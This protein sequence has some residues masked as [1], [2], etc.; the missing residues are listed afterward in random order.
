[1]SDSLQSLVQLVGPTIVQV[2]VTAY[3]PMDRGSAAETDLVIS[4]QRSLGSGVVVDPSGYIL[5]NEHVVSG[6]RRVQVVLPSTGGGPPPGR[7]EGGRRV[8]AQIVGS[9]REFDLAL[10]KID[11]TGLRALPLGDSTAL[12]Q[13]ELVFAFGSPEGLRNSVS[14]G[15]VSAAARQL[16]PDTPLAYIQT[17]AAINHGNSGG[18]LV[19]A[20]GEMVGMN[21]FIYSQSG[22]SEGLGFALPSALIRVAY[23]KLREFG[24]LHRAEVGV[25]LQTVTP[26]L[27]T[28]LH[29]ARQR[30]LIVADVVDGKPAA[31][32]G[33]RIGDLVETLNGE[34]VDSVL[35]FTMRMLACNDGEHVRI[36][37]VRGNRPFL[38]DVAVARHVEKRARITDFID[39]T[40]GVLQTLGIVAVGV[41]PAVAEL[42]PSLRAGSGVVVAAH[43]AAPAVADIELQIGDVIHTVNGES[44]ST[45]EDLRGTLRQIPV[46]QPVVFQ[47]E[48]NGQLSFVTFDAE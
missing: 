11:A 9:T 48:R 35:A 14:M 42:L 18:P 1:L 29:L 25:L 10:L 7:G 23:P 20:R 16:D 2:V 26:G 33:L 6:A 12:H 8:D 28:G 43:S 19:N 39:P 32:A 31:L 34:P 27:A 17:D 13:G 22:G 3:A 47:I 15:V 40:G 38:V 37:G 24:E 45:V 4:R 36:G 21:T 41:T 44:V 5:T 46:G 30:G